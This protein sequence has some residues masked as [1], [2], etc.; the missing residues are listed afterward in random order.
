LPSSPVDGTPGVPQPANTPD[1]A[2]YR[3]VMVADRRVL[4]KMTVD[5]VYGARI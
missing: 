2:E 1:W 4:I 3:A 5:K